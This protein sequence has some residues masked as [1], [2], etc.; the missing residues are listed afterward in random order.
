MTT[1]VPLIPR[2]P[3]TVIVLNS[4]YEPLSKVDVRRAVVLLATDKAVIHEADDTRSLRSAGGG[5]VWPWPLVVRLTRYVRVAFDKLHRPVKWTK[6]GVLERDGHQC[7]YCRRGGV[8]IDHIVP[9]AQGGRS[10]WA[11]T[12][13]S[14][15]PCNSRKANRT[16]VQAGMKL[17]ATPFVPR[18]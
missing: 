8:T 14:C 2:I 13:A 1:A 11:N 3:R 16:P 4:S 9:R 6:K 12:V 5:V 17:L 15:Q 18:R 10:T 7:A